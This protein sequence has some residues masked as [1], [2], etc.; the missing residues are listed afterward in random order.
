MTSQLKIQIE[1]AITASANKQD[2]QRVD[3]D[4]HSVEQLRAVC[5]EIDPECEFSNMGHG[6]F[7]I[8]GCIADPYSIRVRINGLGSPGM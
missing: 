2:V 8:R 6:H 5:A 4:C 7:D 3:A 1:S